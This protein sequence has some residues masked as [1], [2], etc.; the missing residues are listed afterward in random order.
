MKNSHVILMLLV[1]MSGFTHAKPFTPKD[2]GL[3]LERLPEQFFQ[4]KTNTTIKRLRTQLNSNPQDWSSARQLALH[5]IELS[6]T[7]SDPRYMGYAQAVLK[8][9]WEIPQPTI[10]ALIL[11][12]IIR[13][14]AHDFKGA[15]NDLEQVLSMQPR[16]IQANLIKATIATVQG[17]Y[18]TAIQH[19]RQ[20]MRRSSML[21]TLICQST[22]ASL[23]G[24]AEIS[25]QLLN[26]TLSA[27]SAMPE[28]EKTWAWTSLAEIAW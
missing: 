23:S 19:C 15:L 27:A 8:P 5:Y 1:V 6:K 7:Q 4:S 17:D 18:Q 14:N 24:K 10:Q 11:R 2:D 25:Y 20:L 26:Q 21:L 12:A 13:Q 3:V 28:K 9:W 22:P 16:H